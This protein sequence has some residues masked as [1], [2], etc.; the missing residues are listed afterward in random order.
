MTDHRRPGSHRRAHIQRAFADLEER[1]HR[2]GIEIATL[3]S[4][5]E[6]FTGFFTQSLERIMADAKDFDAALA[7]LEGDVGDD[8]AQDDAKIVAQQATINDMQGTIDELKATAAANPAIDFA[9]QIAKLE[10]IRAKLHAPPSGETDVP[11][12]PS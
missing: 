2:T 11:A 8:E 7:K 4:I 1:A 9:P 6:Y 5:A 12:T 10:A 3:Q